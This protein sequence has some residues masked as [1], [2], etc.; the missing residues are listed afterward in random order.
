VGRRLALRWA[1]V[2]A[3]R[4]AFL[5]HLRDE[6]RASP[7]TV[8][9]YAR[10]LDAFL[11]GVQER[12][13]RP[14]QIADFGVR[15]I[16]AHLAQLHG[17]MAPASVARRVSV[18][19]TFGTFLR[20]RGE[21]ADNEAQLVAAPK[22]GR[23]L[24]V[25]LPPEDV[26]RMLEQPVLG[27]RGLRDAAVLELL[28][29]AGLRVAECVGLDRAHLRRD[30]DAAWL[31][32]VS[33]KGGKDRVVPLGRAALRAIAA[34][35]EHRDAFVRPDSPAD[36]LFLGD[37]GRRLGVR[38]VRALVHARSH[39]HARARVGPHGLRH[40]FATHLL[41]SGCD[42]RAIQAM[43]G[44]ASL[45]TTQRYTH[46]DLGQLVDVYDRAHPRAR[47]R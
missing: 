19:R 13:G 14:P 17:R 40:S 11:A 23:Q 18:L 31:R 3:Q 42:L 4:E 27:P 24:P 6:R 36:A 44:H 2:Y 25:A 32:V 7:H 37:R 33:G 41:A 47:G 45:S 38:Q 34:W 21:V 29:G 43:L 1:R 10:D 26:A 39:A 12:T 30:G 22:L 5:Q 16:R 9:A 20:R 28:Y 15:E 46:L 35:L 8:R